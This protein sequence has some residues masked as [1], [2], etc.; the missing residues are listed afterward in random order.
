MASI[1]ATDLKNGASFLYEGKP[2]K[3]LKYTLIK[4]GRGGATVKVKCVNLES[5]ANV[6][7]A[8]S[9]NL[10]FEEVD[11]NKKTL[12]Y[13]YK[14]NSIAYFMNPTNYEQVEVPISIL[15]DDVFY[16]KEGENASV[17]F[18]EK[19]PMSIDLPP[20]VVLEVVE[21]DP[22]VKGNSASN[23]L[24]SAKM[25]NGLTVKVPLFIKKGEKIRVDTRTGEYIERAK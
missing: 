25:E 18:W 17:M 10:S 12:Q 8:F 14:D 9:S 20:K 21:A 13:L 6:D 3:V 5:G 15:G 1:K 24:K 2:F 23:F 11:L 16:L 7:H 22:G 4:L 19:R